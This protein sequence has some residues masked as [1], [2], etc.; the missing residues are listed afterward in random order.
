MDV[1]PGPPGRLE[2]LMPRLKPATHT[3]RRE[4]ILDSAELCFARSGF[5]RTTMHDICKEAGISAGALYVYFSSKEELIAGISERDRNTLRAQISA[6]NSAP[7]LLE[8]LN[9]IGEHY[10]IEEPRRKN[11][12]CIEIGAESTRNSTVG[13]I[14][15]TFDRDMIDAFEQVLT[16]A[17]DEGK[18]SPDL[19]PRT[20]AEILAL[21]GDGLFWRRAVDPTF[22]ARAIMPVLM[23][24]V[25]GFLRPTV[26]TKKKTLAHSGAAIAKTPPKSAHPRGRARSKEILQ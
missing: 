13:D 16:Q 3:A 10:C 8:A 19:A 12:L 15:Q 24:I 18:I 4:H 5:H 2:S 14:Y 17:R 23:Q 11:I 22:D 6:L 26:K 20:A 1:R 21:L 9:R 7:D 25:A